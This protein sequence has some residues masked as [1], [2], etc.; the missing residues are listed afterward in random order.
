MDLIELEYGEIQAI[1]TSKEDQRQVLKTLKDK[2]E[3]QDMKPGK[4]GQHE[5][6]KKQHWDN[7]E[8]F[9]CSARTV[10]PELF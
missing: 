6:M 8:A 5:T 7:I 1:N 4:P 10:E 2:Q 3:A 9:Q